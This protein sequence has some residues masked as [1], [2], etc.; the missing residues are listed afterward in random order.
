M[1][2]HICLQLS[3]V[4]SYLLLFFLSLCWFQLISNLSACWDNHVGRLYSHETVSV[5]KHYSGCMS[6]WLHSSFC[7]TTI[8]SPFSII[9]AQMM[10][11]TLEQEFLSQ[12][13]LASSSLWRWIAH[14]WSTISR[15]SRGLILTMLLFSSCHCG[16][17]LW[18]SKV[19]VFTSVLHLKGTSSMETWCKE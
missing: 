13:I 16:S 2:R 8:I 5:T 6:L 14:E 7:G 19:H 1:A 10:R 3:I 9:Q 12:L 18:P 17:V 11:E 15:S 4:S